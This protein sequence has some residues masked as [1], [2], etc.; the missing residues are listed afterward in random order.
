MMPLAVALIVLSHTPGNPVAGKSV[1]LQNCAVC[2]GNEGHG[3]GPAAAG[4]NPKPANFH[5]P[6]RQKLTADQMVH[7]VTEGGAEE[8]KSPT[9][10]AF[11]D[12]LS[13]QQI[14]DVVAY[15]RTFLFT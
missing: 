11:G 13:Q 9:M 1:F 15:I 12:F 5:L 6:E 7:L 8:K 4:L 2:H 10:P 3:D 14:R